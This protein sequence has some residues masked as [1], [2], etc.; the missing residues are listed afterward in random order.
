MQKNTTHKIP[1]IHPLSVG[2][3]KQWP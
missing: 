1:D 3:S 2:V